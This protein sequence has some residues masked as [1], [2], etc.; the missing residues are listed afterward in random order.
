MHWLI[1]SWTNLELSLIWLI[2]TVQISN[3]CTGY[4]TGYFCPCTLCSIISLNWIRPRHCTILGSI[5]SFLFLLILDTRA[6]KRPFVSK[7]LFQKGLPCEYQISKKRFAVIKELTLN[8]NWARTQT[9]NKSKYIMSRCHDKIQQCYSIQHCTAPIQ[10]VPVWIFEPNSFSLVFLIFH[11]LVFLIS[12]NCN[13]Q[14]TPTKKLVV[15]KI[16]KLIIFPLL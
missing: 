8:I 13:F 10:N 1:E 7:L 9:M 6:Y 5:K 14:H 12:R 3:L 11:I 15:L 16:K 4:L 2:S